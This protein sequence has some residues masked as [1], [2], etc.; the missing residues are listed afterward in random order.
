M[1]NVPEEIADLLRRARQ[2]EQAAFD[3]L[4]ARHRQ[5]VRRGI[6]LRLDRRLAAR[7][8][9]SDVEQETYLEAAR[10]LPAYLERPDMPFHLWLHWLAREQVLTAHRR[11]LAADRR[12]VGREAPPLPVDSSA[13]FVCALVGKG[14]SPSQAAA[15]TEMA[16]RLRLAL[17]QLDE[18]E[19]SILLW[20][21]FE[22]L[23]NR[24]IA[25]ILHISPAAANKR[26]VRALERL[27]GLLLNL[28]VSGMDS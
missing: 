25:Q 12:S 26:Y 13:S 10:R 4:F 1:E 23:T 16:E 15:A 22:Q 2:G 17:G 7:V 24:E 27:R 5:A 11:H 3:E 19:R 18:D 28:G 6:A 21:H 14:P 20:R 8:D 9:V